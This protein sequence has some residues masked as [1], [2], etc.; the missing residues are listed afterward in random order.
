M[1][2]TSLG[3]GDGMDKQLWFFSWNAYDAKT[4]EHLPEYSYGETYVS[5]ASVSAQEIFD[6]LMEQKSKLR[7][8]LRI[9]CI[10]FNKL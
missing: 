8:N 7:D 6:G 5:D 4:W 10:A 1:H 3:K 2:N 9:H